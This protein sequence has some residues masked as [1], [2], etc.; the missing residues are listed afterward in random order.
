LRRV[1]P[2]GWAWAAWSSE[3]KEKG[4]EIRPSQVPAGHA[5]G[6]G[7]GGGGGGGGGDGGLSRV[8]RGPYLVGAWRASAPPTAV[9]AWGHLLLAGLTS[10]T[11]YWLLASKEPRT[12]QGLPLPLVGTMSRI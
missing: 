10:P 9:G 5:S 4:E 2:P 3:E 8:G 12:K 11:A 6:E 1:G 7:G